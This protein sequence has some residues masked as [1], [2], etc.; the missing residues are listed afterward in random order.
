MPERQ[1]I[2]LNIGRPAVLVRHGRQY[3]TAMNRKPADGPVLLTGT[4]FE[5]D[6]VS[7]SQAHGGPDRAACCYPIEHYDHW[8]GRLDAEM[9]V[10]SFGE[11]LTTRGLFEDEIC[12]GDILAMG[13]AVV[14]ISSPR[15]PC[16]K[17][18][19]KHDQPSLPAW[20]NETGFCGFYVGVVQEGS[21]A[22][23][24]GV[25]LVER[26]HAGMTVALAARLRVA[27]RPDPALI[28]QFVQ[29]TPLS[30]SFRASL[31]ARVDE[32]EP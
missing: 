8:R 12:I 23:G 21:I 32:S 31:L 5:G 29:E 1:I 20:I 6:R 11:N 27:T 9:P 22:T 28:E 30:Q 24:D 16:A 3:S 2:S 13:G 10:P 7:D 26:P 19:L 17:L 18:A 14:T 25:R 15:Q 4:G